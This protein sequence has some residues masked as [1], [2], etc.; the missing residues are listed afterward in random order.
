MTQ[1]SVT[2][3]SGLSGALYR[4]AGNSRAQ[5]LQTMQRGSDEPTGD[6]KVTGSR[7]QD[8][9][10]GVTGVLEKHYDGTDW[11]TLLE[12]NE[13]ANTVAWKGLL[14]ADTLG[15][16]YT[17]AAQQVFSTGAE[18]PAMLRYSGAGTGALKFPVKR[19]KTGSAAAASD[20]LFELPVYGLDAA[21]N[22]TIY[23]KL[24]LG[25]VT[26]TDGNEAG[27]WGLRALTSAAENVEITIGGGIAIGSA[28]PRGHGTF[29]TPVSGLFFGSNQVGTNAVGNR[30]IS[31]AAPSGGQDGD[32]WLKI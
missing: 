2:I 22:E 31:S 19:L 4:A 11:I 18:A 17:W 15:V 10:A 7:W 1:A 24:T 26:A 25:I 16:A 8:D 9:G 29:V 27:R 6:R 23:G 30:T 12:I 28:V 21:G 13:T 14:S 20:A 5:A 32:L 3:S